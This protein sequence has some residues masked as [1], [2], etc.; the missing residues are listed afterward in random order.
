MKLI[1]PPGVSQSRFDLALAAFAGIVGKEWV[2]STDED[3]E[4]YLD[5]YAPGDEASMQPLPP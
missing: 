3:R 5:A 2:L 1:L 4:T